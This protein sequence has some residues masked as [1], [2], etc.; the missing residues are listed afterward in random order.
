MEITAFLVKIAKILD[1]LGIPYA[2]TGG[3]AVS[4]WGRV[5]HT[6]DVDIIVELV[7]Q[8]ISMLTKALLQFDK[9]VYVSQEAIKEALKHK[10]EFN[11]IDPNTRLKADFWIVKDYFAEEEIKR[12]VAKD[13]QG[14]KVNFVCPEDLILSKLLWYR[15]SESTR[16]LEDIESIL[17]ISKVDVKYVRSLAE[18]QGTLDILDALIKKI[19]EK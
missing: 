5:R 19:G 7:P 10:G 4:I 11:F 17:S 15:T 14:Y 12:A 8:N 3:M 1:G 16:Q 2:I 6:A 13:I 9:D 18:K